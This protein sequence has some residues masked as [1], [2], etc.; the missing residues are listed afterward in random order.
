MCDT[1]LHFDPYVEAAN[2]A[3]SLDPD[4]LAEVVN[5]YAMDFPDSYITFSTVERQIVIEEAERLIEE[6]PEVLA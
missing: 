2:K 1:N 6:N 3:A 4:Y 5:A